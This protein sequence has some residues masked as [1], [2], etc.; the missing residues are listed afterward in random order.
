[1]NIRLLI[2]DVDGVLTDGRFLLHGDDG[3]AKA[4]HSVD[5]LGLRLLMSSGVQIAFLTGRDTPVVQ[6]RGKELGVQTILQ[7]RHDKLAAAQELVANLG[8]PPEQAAYMGD[9]LMDLPAMKFVGFSAAPADARPE[10]RDLAD[11]VA[12][13]GGGQGAV[14]DLCE[15]ILRGM[16]LWD[17]LVARYTD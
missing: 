6:R 15:H 1:M 8:L 14:R 5:G 9:D 4:F 17:G 11:Y 12:P 2:L 16:G 7:G 3:E 10:V 13:S